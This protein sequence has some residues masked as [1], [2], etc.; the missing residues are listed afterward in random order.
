[1]LSGATMSV[2]KT[3]VSDYQH[4]PYHSK[5]LTPQEEERVRQAAEA[6]TAE[7]AKTAEF[8]VRSTSVPDAY[9]EYVRNRRLREGGAS[10]VGFRNVLAHVF[11]VP[12][13][14]SFAIPIVG[15]LFAALFFTI[16][17]L[18][19][20]GVKPRPKTPY[21]QAMHDYNNPDQARRRAIAQ[22]YGVTR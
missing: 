18:L 6:P 5:P 15:G 21:E 13:Y 7:F 19:Q 9:L 16:S 17:A 4:H 3:I 11:L 20:I 10:G 2:G 22:Q 1:M 14:A 12:A 8:A